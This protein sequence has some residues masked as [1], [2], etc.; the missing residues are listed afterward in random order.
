[1]SGEIERAAGARDAR[2]IDP[3]AEVT[4]AAPGV[5]HT[6]DAVGEHRRIRDFPLQVRVSGQHV[7]D[8]V[9]RRLMATHLP[10]GVTRGRTIEY[11]VFGEDV[12]D[13]LRAGAVPAIDPAL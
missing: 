11:E 6:R 7:A 13:T 8:I 3:A 10:A 2:R 4:G 12:P 5:G 9:H 1:M